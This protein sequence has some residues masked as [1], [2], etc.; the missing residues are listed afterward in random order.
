MRGD[1]KP[2]RTIPEV[3]RVT[4][5]PWR[6]IEFFLQRFRREGSACMTRRKKKAV[7]RLEK[8]LTDSFEH[9]KE[10][11]EPA[12][13]REWAHLSI[14]QRRA[15]IHQRY[16]V[17]RATKTICVFYR[18]HGIGYRKTYTMYRPEVN[19][20]DEFL[21]RRITFAE[22]L[23]E[24]ILSDTP[25][26]YAD[27]L[28]VNG[29]ARLA[30][31]WYR[32]DITFQVPLPSKRGHGQTVFVCVSTELDRILYHV[33]RSTCIA[34][35]SDFIDV[36]GRNLPPRRRYQRKPY[37]VLDNASAHHNKSVVA[38]LRK[39]FQPRFIVAYS[40]QFNSAEWGNGHVRRLYNAR[41]TQMA[42]AGDFG[43]EDIVAAA[44]AACQGVTAE[45]VR[46]AAVSNRS[47]INSFL[48][49]EK[50]LPRLGQ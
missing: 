15:L 5:V 22:E 31:S 14:R 37:I 17:M 39:H 18:L 34:D 43:Q 49:I 9:D 27:E 19:K 35:F 11:L 1:G 10:L 29:W 40:C 2:I 6:T 46:K 16:G 25:I 21:A 45:Q 7:L 42:L 20:P 33:G 4:G 48:P 24:M 38:K 26:Y 30:R 13:L 32:T 41:I 8:P 28:S 50:H 47:Y 36:L 23:R 12:L 3:A 44:E